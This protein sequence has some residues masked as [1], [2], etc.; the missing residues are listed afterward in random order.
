MYELDITKCEGENC[1]I[2]E[3][4]L[5]YVSIPEKYQSYFAMSPFMGEEG[6]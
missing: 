6:I 4:C 5:R 2:R 3:D 1:P